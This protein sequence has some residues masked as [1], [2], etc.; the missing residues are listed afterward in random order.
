[1][2]F[3]VSFSEGK[4]KGYVCEIFNGHFD[5][6]DLGPIGANGLA[7]PRHFLYPTAAYEDIE[8]PFEIV[9]KFQGLMFSAQQV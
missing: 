8:Q 6:P 4:G 7:Y 3:S 9:N 5:L 1:M 2:R